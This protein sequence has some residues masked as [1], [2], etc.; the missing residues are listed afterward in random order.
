MFKMFVDTSEPRATTCE[1]EV[2]GPMSGILT[3]LFY[4]LG[5]FYSRIKKADPGEADAFR[6]FLALAANDPDSPLWTI[7]PPPAEVDSVTTNG[8]EA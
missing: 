5:T 3:D 6:H 1:L 2:T 7:D 4:G 8:G